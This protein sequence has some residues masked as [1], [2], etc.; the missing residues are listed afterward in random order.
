MDPKLQELLDILIAKP[1][2]SDHLKQDLNPLMQAKIIPS[3][4]FSMCMAAP[5]GSGKSTLLIH[6]LQNEHFYKDFFKPKNIYLFSSTGKSDKLYKD[7]K[8]PKKNIFTKDMIVNLDK[9]TKK[10]KK[11]TDG[12]AKS[13][14]CLLLFEDSTN[15]K[16]LMNSKAFNNCFVLL[17]HYNCSIISVVHKFKSLVRTSRLSCGYIIIFPSS[18]SECQAIKDDYCPPSMN[19]RNFM[20][21]LQY[22]WTP[23][24]HDAKPW[25]L[26]DMKSPMSTR[27]RKGFYEVLKIQDQGGI[28]DSNLQ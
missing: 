23:T 22:A 11:K 15:E 16:K 17:R 12:K 9:F 19:K 7:V 25:L 6:M 24:E 2:P 5:S 28:D 26:I 4:P 21:M 20:Q 10:Q 14:P 27:F 13:E 8:I 1:L 18:L 3:H